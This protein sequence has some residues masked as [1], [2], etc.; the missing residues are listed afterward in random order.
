MAGDIDALLAEQIAYY[1]GRA[2]E[3]DKFYA[4]CHLPDSLIDDLPLGGDAL[5]LACGTGRWTPVLARHARAVTAVDAAP[6]MLAL[7]RRR[8]AD[9]PVEFVLADVFT[10]RPTRRYDTVFFAFWLSHVPPARSGAF[11]AMLR[12]VLAPRGRVCFLDTSDVTRAAE[13]PLAGQPAPAVR[14][15]L[16]DGRVY[17]VVKT[18]YAPAQLT[19]AL[20]EQGWSARV[21]RA[22]PGLLIGSATPM[23]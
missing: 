3:Y 23:S 9:L 22:Q 10:W 15:R 11:W 4:A 18:F 19:A 8:A 14:R 20:A 1:R 7:A 6:E 17:R 12:E 13:E 2:A 5:E 21:R 16:D